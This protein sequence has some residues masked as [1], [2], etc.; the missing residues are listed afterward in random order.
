[1][2]IYFLL[3][4]LSDIHVITF[5]YF[6]QTPIFLATATNQPSMIQLLLRCGADPNKEAVSTG[7]SG[8][9]YQHRGPLHYAAQRGKKWIESVRMLLKSSVDVNK[10]DSEGGCHIIFHLS[11]FLHCKITL[12]VTVFKLMNSPCVK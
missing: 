8:K 6:L 9:E 1:M 10:T 11:I 4:P 7:S 5:L 2:E 3:S 12:I